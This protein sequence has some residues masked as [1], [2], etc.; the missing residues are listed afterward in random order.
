MIVLYW[1]VRGFGNSDTRIALK[2][3]YASHKPVFIFLAELM[4]TF[5][6]VPSW[7]WH[8]IGVTK[9]SHIFRE[10]NMCADK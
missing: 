6:H 2:N 1:N 9:T 4:I 3:L 8:S 5:S 7:Y 10:G